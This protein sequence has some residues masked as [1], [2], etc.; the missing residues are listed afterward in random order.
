MLI[1]RLGDFARFG[2]KM[3]LWYWKVSL[4]VIDHTCC[5]VSAGEIIC[6]QDGAGVLMWQELIYLLKAWKYNHGLE[7]DSCIFKAQLMVIYWNNCDFWLDIYLMMISYQISQ[8]LKEERYEFQ[9]IKKKCT[10]QDES[11]HLHN[12]KIYYLLVADV[13][14]WFSAIRLKK[15]CTRIYTSWGVPK[16]ICKTFCMWTSSLLIDARPFRL[17]F[18]SNF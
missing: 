13:P 7:H 18:Y 10:E 15:F 12:V 17:Y 5:C 4:L 14:L 3:D 6:S 1:A 9:T 8:A 16:Y 11:Q 2:F